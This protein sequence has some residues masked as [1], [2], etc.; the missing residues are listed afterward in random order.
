MKRVI[1]V[2]SLLV[3]GLGST[4]AFCEGEATETTKTEGTEAA[5][6]EAPVQPEEEK[7][8]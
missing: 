5:P 4:I 8:D 6:V 3:S 2:A 1:L 7:K